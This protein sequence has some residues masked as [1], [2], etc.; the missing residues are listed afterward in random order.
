MMYSTY[1]QNR[2]EKFFV[3]WAAKI[4]INAGKNGDMKTSIL[5]STHLLIL[6]SSEYKVSQMIF[7]MYVGYIIDYIRIYFQKKIN[8]RKCDFRFF[9]K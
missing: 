4:Y 3:L 7:C 1:T 5:R 9:F 6:C 2:N 8:T